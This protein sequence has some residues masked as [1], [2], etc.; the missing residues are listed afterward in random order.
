MFFVRPLQIA[1]AAILML[2]LA[3]PA[4]AAKG[5]ARPELLIETD[6][7]AK[8]MGQPNVRVVDGVDAG[9]YRRAHIPGAV[10]LFYQRLAVLKTRKQNGF[11]AN[12]QDAE[13]IFGE[14][15][16]DNNTLVVVYD[17][18]EGPVASALWF[19]L[20]FFGHKKVKVLNGGFRKW[21]KEGRPVTQEVPKVEA[22]KF[23]AV[24][25]PEKVVTAEVV[26]KRDQKTVLAD[27]RSFKEFI[28]QDLVP[29]ASRGGHIPG[30]VNLEW[31]QIAGSL[32]TF[33][34]ADEIMKVFEKKGITKDTKAITY[35]QLGFGRSTM[36]ELGMRLV[37]YDQ[38]RLY[39]GSWEDW[40][41]DPRLPL[42]K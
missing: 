9:T 16:I 5:Y 11:P 40:S 8:L 12:P 10:N 22:K 27:A 35:C 3:A 32:E 42:E 34:P 36:L 28:G 17:G 24:P 30:A 2:V 29:G 1:L 13:K 41:A 14:A 6:E 33:K 25:H 7:L 26:K 39:S 23:T 20:D 4:W 31:T 37:G 38:S 19:A 18:G 15:G 21:V